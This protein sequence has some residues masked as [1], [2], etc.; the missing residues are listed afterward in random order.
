MTIFVGTAV[1]EHSMLA[2]QL[3]TVCSRSGRNLRDF[4]LADIVDGHDREARSA[5]DHAHEDITHIIR[6]GE[7][8]AESR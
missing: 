1:L 7:V 5:V 3:H 4:G 6:S 2:D 8:L